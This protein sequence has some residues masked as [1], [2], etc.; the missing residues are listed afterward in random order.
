[1][2]YGI[3]ETIKHSIFFLYTKLFWPK[4]RLIRLPVYARTKK[5]IK[6][7]KGLTT[8]YGCRFA[9]VSNSII[10]IGENVTFGDYV[11]LQSSNSIVI[12]DNVLFASRIFVGDSNHGIYSGKEQTDPSI[13]PNIRPLNVGEIRIGD[14]VWIGNGVTIVGNVKIGDGAIVGANSV[15]TKDIDAYCIYIGA[16]AKKIK[17]WDSESKKW[18]PI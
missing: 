7:S 15:V 5:N 18:K 1:M 17:Q 11:Q 6:Y 10:K 13:P 14:N 2:Y 4:A 16:P 12:G 3:G 9:A 8:G